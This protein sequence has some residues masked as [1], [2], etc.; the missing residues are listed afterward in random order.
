[1]LF[2]VEAV[3]RLVDLLADDGAPAQVRG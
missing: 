3:E 1:L 2:P